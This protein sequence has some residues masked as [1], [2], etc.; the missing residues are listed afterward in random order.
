MAANG[1]GPAPTVSDQ[2]VRR[3]ALDQ[4]LRLHRHGADPV[5]VVETAELFREFLNAEIDFEEA[6]A[7]ESSDASEDTAPGEECDCGGEH[8]EVPSF[9]AALLLASRQLE[10]AEEGGK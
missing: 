2:G 10:V 9:I 4:A 7:A 8:I 6:E 1:K 5:V 3:E